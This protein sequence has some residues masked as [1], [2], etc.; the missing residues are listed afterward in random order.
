MRPLTDGWFEC[1]DARSRAGTRYWYEIDGRRRVPDPAARFMPDG[2]HAPSEVVDPEQFVWPAGGAA[3]V[4]AQRELIFYELHVGTFTPQGT[5]AAAAAHLQDLAGLGITAIELMPL[6]Q[7]PG[8]FNWGYD[9]VGLY[10]PAH[11]YGRPEELKAFVGHAH[12][13]GLCVFLDVVYN[14][15]GPEGNYLHCYAPAFFD[16]RRQ[17]PWGAA[18]DYAAPANEAVRDYAIENVCYWLCEYRFDGVRLDAVDEIAGD[19]TRALLDELSQRARRARAG[20]CISLRRARTLPG[21]RTARAHRA[22]P[23]GA[24]TCTTACTPPLRARA[25]AT[26]ATLRA[27]RPSGS[28]VR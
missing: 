4:R 13:L 19:A 14:H 6:A 1:V 18:I 10:A 28:D 12:A 3:C 7:A 11:A 2:P 15:F 8:P 21:S 17:T 26:I 23:S 27:L 5:Y 16:A 20:R 9:G 24:T 25:T 22:M